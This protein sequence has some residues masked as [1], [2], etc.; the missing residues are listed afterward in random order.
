MAAVLPSAM[1]MGASC[2][3]ALMAVVPAIVEETI[4]RGAFITRTVKGVLW[5]VFLS[6]LLFGLMH[7]NFEPDAYAFFWG[8]F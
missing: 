6:A 2:G 8:S 7:M 1:S 3:S 5:Q 4:F